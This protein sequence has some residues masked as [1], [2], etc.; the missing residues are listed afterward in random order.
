MDSFLQKEIS[1][2]DYIGLVKDTS[3]SLALKSRVVIFWTLN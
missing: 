2:K 3:V 1:F